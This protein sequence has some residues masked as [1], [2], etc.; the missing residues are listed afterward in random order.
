MQKL[1]KDLA[2]LDCRLIPSLVLRAMGMH[3]VRVWL[4]DPHDE[5]LKNIVGIAYCITTSGTTGTPKVVR[6][7]YSCI[8]PN[9]ADFRS[10]V[11]F[12]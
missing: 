4:N 12:C 3:L 9:V 10:Y 7:P 6:V 5:G 1:E 2:K 11:Y 8:S